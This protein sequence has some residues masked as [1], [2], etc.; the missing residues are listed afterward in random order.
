MSKIFQ[1]TDENLNKAVTVFYEDGDNTSGISLLKQ[2]TFIGF[3]TETAAAEGHEDD[4]QAGLD[5]HRSRIRL[6]QFARET[7]DGYEVY[8]YDNA[9]INDRVRDAIRELLE[10]PLPVKIGHNLKFDVKMVRKH[11]RVRRFG[12][13]FC[14]ELMY[15]LT[16]CGQYVAGR[17][18]L[19]DALYDCLGITLEKELQR[20]NWA[21]PELDDDQLIYAAKDAYVVF[22]LRKSLVA[23]IEQLK[24]QTAAVYDL[25]I[26][27]PIADLEINGL[28]IVPELWA[29][30]DIA[31]RKRRT[32]IMEQINDEFRASG[33]VAQQGL[34]AGAPLVS[35]KARKGMKRDVPT[36]SITSPKQIAAY[37]EAYGIELPEKVDRKTKKVSKTTGT[38]WLKPKKFSKSYKVIPLL[39]EF[40]ELD[41]RK[42][43]YGSD[44]T[45]KY[46]N[47]VTGR[48]HAD[49]DPQG[50]KTARFSCNK[51]NLQQ[52]PQMQEYRSCFVAP[53]GW[54]FVG[55]DF[56]QIELRIA[57]ELSGDSGY[58]N[59]FL[60]GEDFHAKTAEFMFG[61]KKGDANYDIMRFYAKRINFGIIYGMGA[62][63]LAMQTDLPES[64]PILRLEL[65]A[66]AGLIPDAEDWLL[67][68]MN[69]T[70]WSKWQVL[71]KV[72]DWVN[73]GKFSTPEIEEKVATTDTAQDYLERY[74]QTFDTLMEFLRTQ[75][76]NTAKY[77]QTRMASGRLVKFWVNSEDRGSMAQAERNGMNTPIQG[78]AGEILKIAVRLWFDRVHEAGLDDRIKLVH[79]VHDEL[80]TMCRV[81]DAPL[82]KDLLERAM[83]EAGE[84]YLKQVPVKVDVKVNQAWLK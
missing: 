54:V 7:D 4:S 43:S 24:L 32:A 1:F 62:S 58:I 51:P 77:K 68:Q 40:R 71:R 3:D 34:F 18:S 28:P 80:Q 48:I 76:K 9:Y 67:A 16:K 57:A 2:C 47:P 69:E 21:K 65:M 26:I 31:M 56:S 38:P 42:T 22:P 6:F 49:F 66:E 25:G 33:A 27:D 61:V 30:T 53:N 11:I 60:S 52:I 50:T 74:Y 84:V 75:G 64:K 82:A 36:N 72:E 44:Y 10:Q 17:V 8:I 78:L 29:Q 41:K 37:L 35:R 46:C 83:V 13:L 55:G 5:P 14:T 19:A 70:G 79:T 81:E 15:R 59:A 20:S 73:Q 45:D 23:A 63:K 39:L 12:R